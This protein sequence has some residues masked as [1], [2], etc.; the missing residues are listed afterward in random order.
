[1][2]HSNEKDMK[3]YAEAVG[4]I[5]SGLFIVTTVNPKNNHI[6]GYLASWVQQFSFKPLLIAF[7]SN[8]SRPGYESIVAGEIVTLN[9]VADQDSQYLKHFW[10][11]YPSGEGPFAE[12]PHHKTSHG[13]I[14]IDAAKSAIECKMVQKI[15]PGDHDIIIAEVIDSTSNNQEAKPKVHIRKNG[16]DY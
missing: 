4:H 6:D 7:A 3:K 1:M 10:K 13:G 16:L 12:I 9:I 8:P 11:G 15:R 5:P 2:P 14:V